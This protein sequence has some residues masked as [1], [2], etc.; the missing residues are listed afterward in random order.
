MV[1]RIVFSPEPEILKS[2]PPFDWQ[3]FKKIVNASF[4]QRRKT[5]LNGL[6]AGGFA[7]DKAVLGEIIEKAGISPSIRAEKLSFGQFVHLSNII[8]KELP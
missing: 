8:Q 1:I 4:A 6:T 2:V 3:L 7:A 5:L